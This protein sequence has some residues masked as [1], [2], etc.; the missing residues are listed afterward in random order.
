L[1][2]HLPT[3][4]QP[5]AWKRR[6]ARLLPVPHQQNSLQQQLQPTL[7]KQA[8]VLQLHQQQLLL[9]LLQLVLQLLLLLPAM[10]SPAELQNVWQLLQQLICRG[11]LW[12]LAQVLHTISDDALQRSP[13]V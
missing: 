1:L 2:L 7:Q 10:L 4:L 6:A 11:A 5:S 12:L 3:A 9:A 8:W 13:Q